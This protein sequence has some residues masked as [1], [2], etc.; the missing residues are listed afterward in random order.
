MTA[1]ELRWIR[2]HY[3]PLEGALVLD[4]GAGE[5]HFLKALI[6]E[7]VSTSSTGMDRAWRNL[8]TGPRVLCGRFPDDWH[9]DWV[10]LA[11]FRDSL[12]YLDLETAAQ[13]LKGRCGAV[14]LKTVD[15]EGT[16]TRRMGW[17]ARTG[18][19][20]PPQ[21]LS[22]ILAAFTAAGFTYVWESPYPEHT[23]L[24]LGAQDTPWVRRCSR[25]VDPVLRRFLRPDKV[26]LLL[27]RA[28]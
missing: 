1:W 16:R 10:D 24:T 17:R 14:Y 12:Y 26:V 6:G 9:D 18:S 20:Q 25:V 3:G 28:G 13:A 2:R 8:L 27:R 22:S 21:G 5:G 19:S 11:C 15:P 4:V 7:G 23:L